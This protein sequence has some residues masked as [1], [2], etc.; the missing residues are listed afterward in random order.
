ME[1]VIPWA[2]LARIA[3]VCGAMWAAIALTLGRVP[4]N[5]GVLLAEVALGAA[6]YIAGLFVTGAVRAD[7]RVYVR[8]LAAR[9]WR[10]LSGRAR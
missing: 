8:D 1:W 4:G 7:E 9:V 3:A 2:D 6:V 10:R 5:I